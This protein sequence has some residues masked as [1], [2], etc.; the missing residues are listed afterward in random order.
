MDTDNLTHPQGY[1]A[2][3]QRFIP[4]GFDHTRDVQGAQQSGSPDRAAAE[5]GPA[6]PE[7]KRPDS[8][9]SGFYQNTNGSNFQSEQ[10]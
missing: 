9:Q 6:R 3:K 1:E 7:G 10:K 8:K 2:I 4:S 5:P